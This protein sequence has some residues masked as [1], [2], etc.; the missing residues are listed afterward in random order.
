MHMKTSATTPAAAKILQG[1]ALTPWE[2]YVSIFDELNSVFGL[3]IPKGHRLEF[4]KNSQFG[5][6]KQDRFKR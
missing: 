3:S 6:Q 2:E 1:C 4:S 5:V